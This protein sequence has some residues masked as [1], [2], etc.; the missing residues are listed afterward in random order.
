MLR[1]LLA[2]ICALG[3]VGCATAAW[4]QDFPAHPLR[5]IV[6]FG[7]GAGTD[8]TGRLAADELSQRIGQ[9][10]VVENK[11]GAG[12]QI[13]IDFV[14]KSRPDGYTL[15]WTASDGIAVLPAV[16]PVLPYKVPE[17]FTFIARM[18]VLPYVVAVNPR[19]PIKSMADLI[20]YAKA[21]PGKLRYGTS[22][23]GTATHMG[24]ALIAKTAGIEMLHVPYTGVAAAVTAVLGD[25]VDVV[26]AAP[27][28]IKPHADAGTLRALAT[29]GKERYP[30]FPDTPTLDEAG[31][32]NVTVI[33]W[34]G[35]MAAAGMPD[36][37]QAKLRTE[38]AEMLKDPKVIQR[39]RALGY[40]PAFLGGADFRD[41]VVKDL[42][43]WKSVAKGAGIALE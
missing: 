19:L 8:A 35:M 29:T 14:A 30:L 41:F 12:S 36:A 2:A 40:Q 1:S 21:N 20:A 4:A 28:S 7:P 3:T 18:I 5:V 15:L 16:K 31:L 39:L 26:L 42:E 17:D 33:V 24:T 10:I 27:S 37:V 32:P 11:A 9:P 38:I 25:S 13:G 34:Y 43:Q 6:P 22:G 23:I